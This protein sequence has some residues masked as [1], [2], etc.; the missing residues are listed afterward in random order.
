MTEK[1][2]LDKG[3]IPTIPVPHDFVI[4]EIIC[5]SEFLIFKFRDD[6]LEFDCSPPEYLKPK[7]SSLIMKIHLIDE[8]DTYKYE[9][10]RTFS[11]EGYTL[12]NNKKLR[13]SEKFELEYIDHNIGFCSIIIKLYQRGFYLLDIRADYI[14]YQWL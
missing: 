10:K 12:I 6:I 7:S 11:Q 1:F 4:E 2:Y 13:T 14:E 5:E 9:L 8:F 3:N